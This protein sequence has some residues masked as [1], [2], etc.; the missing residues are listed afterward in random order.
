MIDT[1][2]IVCASCGE[3]FEVGVDPDGG[4]RQTV[5]EDCWVCCRP[6]TVELVL[7]GEGELERV[8][9]SAE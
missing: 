5:V 2:T 9:V 6:N 3:S 4:R 7:D 8:S 1:T